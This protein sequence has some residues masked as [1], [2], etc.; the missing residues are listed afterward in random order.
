[1][2]ERRCST[3]R[4]NRKEKK[5]KMHTFIDWRRTDGRFYCSNQNSEAFGAMTGYFDSCEDWEDK[6]T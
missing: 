2:N 1:M 3:C 6:A 5:D 4:Y